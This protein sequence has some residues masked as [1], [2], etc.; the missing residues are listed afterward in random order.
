M[1]DAGE[2]IR[3]RAPK[4]LAEDFDSVGIKLEGERAVV[5]RGEAGKQGRSLGEEAVPKTSGCPKNV[6]I[7][8]SSLFFCEFLKFG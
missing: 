8:G 6:E 4:R 5:D 7:A 2:C 3:L 1:E